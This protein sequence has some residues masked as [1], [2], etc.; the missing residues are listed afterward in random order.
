M[1]AGRHLLNVL[2]GR[3]A[4]QNAVI[5][6]PVMRLWNNTLASDAPPGHRVWA[7]NLLS[8]AFSG[9]R[10]LFFD[11]DVPHIE[12]GDG[13]R[14]AGNVFPHFWRKWTPERGACAIKL[15]GAAYLAVY[16]GHGERFPPG[17]I[18]ADGDALERD[19][20]RCLLA[21][22]PSRS[23]YGRL[24]PRMPDDIVGA[25]AH[26]HSTLLRE[27]LGVD[28]DEN[29][30]VGANATAGLAFATTQAQLCLANLDD[31]RSTDLWDVLFRT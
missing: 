9:L 26:V 20:F 24:A 4:K 30:Y 15:F 16:L 8:A 17:D 14:C 22:A 10:P 12:M 23:L 5:S 31:L 1:G 3:N 28:P 27:A 19:V 21:A 7:L 11:T 6:A 25:F 29:P 2:S 13:S 18:H